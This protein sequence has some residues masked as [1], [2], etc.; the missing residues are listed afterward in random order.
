[1]PQG[2]VTPEQ[3]AA[4]K[5]R[6]RKILMGF[7]VFIGLIVLLESP[8]ARIRKMD[9]SGNTSVSQSALIA[10]SGLRLGQSL[11]QVKPSQV[12][13]KIASTIPIVQ[14]STVQT[15]W[16]SGTVSIQ[17]HERDVVAVYE[18]DGKFYQLLNNGYAFNEVSPGQGFSFPVITGAQSTV[19]LHEIVSPD[20]ASVCKQIDR[21][22]AGT[23][24]TISEFHVN[25]DGTISIYLDNGFVVLAET[26]SLVGATNAMTQ[27]VNYFAQQ[28]YKPGT[29]DLTGQP[30]YRYT[31]FATSNSSSSSNST[32]S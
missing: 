15:D 5:S 30:P 2:S 13:R 32:N 10:A 31:P 6:N 26:S 8:L 22:D 11:W 7:F 24:S 14:S 16:M 12:N 17:V 4:R 1:M 19:Q 23:L 9:V 28:G 21:I 3:R 29:V 18:V 25:G 20:V 27:A